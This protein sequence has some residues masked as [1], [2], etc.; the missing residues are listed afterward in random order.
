MKR[1]AILSDTHGLLRPEVM[2]RLETV[3]IILHAGDFDT[4][5]VA[6]ALRRRGDFYGIRGNNDWW[7]RSLAKTL[8]FTIEGIRFFM[9]HDRRDIPRRLPEVDVVIYGHSHKYACETRDGI[10][11]L[12]PGSCGRRRFGGE[13]SFLIMEAQEGRFTLEK[14]DI[15]KK[16]YT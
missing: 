12:N 2:E 10:L 7:A 4:E 11:W 1:I 6:E 5:P 3:D 13:L 15:E 9:V 14:V 16:K 8:T